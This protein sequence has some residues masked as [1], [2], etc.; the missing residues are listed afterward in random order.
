[1]DYSVYVIEDRLGKLYKGM[2]SN[3]EK[4]LHYHDSGFNRWTKNRDPFKLV[5][6]E[7]GLTKSDSLRRECFLKLG[8]GREFLKNKLKELSSNK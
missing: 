5:H 3:L 7:S 2:T 6:F 4:R 1:M 8:K